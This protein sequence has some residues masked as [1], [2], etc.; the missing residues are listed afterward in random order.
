MSSIERENGADLSRQTVLE[1]AASDVQ[2]IFVDPGI[3]GAA[4]VQAFEERLR[5]FYPL[6]DWEKLVASIDVRQPVAL[7]MEDQF[8]GKNART[9]KETIWQAA[10]LTGYLAGQCVDRFV[11]VHVIPSTWQVEQA[12]RMKWA[13]PKGRAEGIELALAEF[14]A[15][16]SKAFCANKAQREGFASAFGISKWWE[17]LVADVRRWT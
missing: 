14:D 6:D 17:G 5:V 10:A 3:H 13:R 7:F 16:Y 15:N 11:V 1:L 8:L 4:V 2:W 12:A 9:L